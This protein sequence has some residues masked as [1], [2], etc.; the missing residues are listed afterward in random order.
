VAALIEGRVDHAW[1][2]WVRPWALTAW[3]F[4]TLGIA[5]GS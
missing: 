2:R 5:M 3:A 4:L 1:A